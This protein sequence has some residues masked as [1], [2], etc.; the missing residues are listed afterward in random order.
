MGGLTGGEHSSLPSLHRVMEPSGWKVMSK[1]STD[2]DGEDT[3]I[4]KPS[5]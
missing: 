5:L 4:F 1:K 3:V 2:V